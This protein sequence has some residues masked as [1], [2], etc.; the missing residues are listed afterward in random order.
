MPS[1]FLPAAIVFF[2]ALLTCK[3]VLAASCLV[4]PED[5]ANGAVI[6]DRGKEQMLSA[7]TL[8]PDCSQVTLRRGVIHVLYETQDGVGKRQTCKDLNKPCS[9]DAG[10]GTSFLETLLKLVTY[11]SVPGGKKM[12]KD[13]SRL[14][15]IP[16]GKV[17]SIE[18]A[19][20]FDLAKAG[21]T[22]WNLTLMDT[23]RKTPI[24]RKSG[25]DPVVRIPSNLLRPGGKYTVLIDGA[26]QKYRGGFDILGGTEAQDV[27]RQIRQATNDASATGRAR[28]L[29]EL[30]TF[31]ENNLDYEMELLRE[32]LKL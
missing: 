15:G 22:H 27:A 30:I 24:Y 2:A 8:L 13:V 23:D 31:Y 32:E 25:S 19:A 6:L 14:P 10:T 28:K 5:Q 1:K 18:K 9:V 21:L 12:D 20:T 26:N 4:V 16:H 7:R 29:D 17:L 3:A 11:Q